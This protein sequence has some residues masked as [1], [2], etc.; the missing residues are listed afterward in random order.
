V[1]QSLP[2]PECRCTSRLQ[3]TGSAYCPDAPAGGGSWDDD[4]SDDDDRYSNVWNGWNT[5]GR[6]R[7]RR[8][9]HEEAQQD[10]Q[11]PGR[12]LKG[13]GYDCNWQN[14]NC[15]AVSAVPNVPSGTGC[16]AAP[17]APVMPPPPPARPP[18]P[19][20]TS[21]DDDDHGDDDDSWGSDSGT[22]GWRNR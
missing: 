12:R 2:E 10:L 8:L 1:S 15:N 22:W 21:S 5:H 11:N 19:K 4:N 18:P 14:P 13:K 7:R 9:L 3:A 20:A 17:P 16:I 6:D